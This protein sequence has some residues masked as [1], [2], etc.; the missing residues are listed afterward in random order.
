MKVENSPIIWHKIFE[1][2]EEAL[3]L[4]LL[5]KTR[6]LR[7]GLKKVCIAHTKDGLFATEDACPHKM[8]KLTAGHIIPNTNE[9]ECSWHQYTFDLCTGKE[10]TG[11]VIRDLK[12]YPLK[13]TEE[14]LFVGI[15]EEPE[16]D[17]FSF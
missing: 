8:I 4:I 15:Q 6:S 16:K 5:N 3:K 1:S 7:I 13:E 14:G 11:K 17:P 10:T 12:I 9:I 2:K